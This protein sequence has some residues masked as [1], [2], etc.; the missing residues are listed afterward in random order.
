MSKSMRFSKWLLE[1][2]DY[3]FG[4]ESMKNSNDLYDDTEK[5]WSLFKTEE[6]FNELRSLI[7]SDNK[8]IT[9]DWQTYIDWI[10][11]NN[12]ISV[13]INPFGSLRI[14]TRKTIKDLNGDSVN[15]CKHVFDVNDHDVDQEKNIANHIY[16]RAVEAS[17]DDSDYA[18]GEYNGTKKLARELF[19]ATQSKHPKN[20]MFP[21]KFLEMNS[22]YY[23]IVFEFRGSGAGSPNQSTALQFNIDIIFDKEKG[24][25]RCWGYDIDS[26]SNKKQFNIKPSEWDEYFSPQESNSKIISIIT[27][28]FMTY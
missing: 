2:A 12:N 1:Y 23:K 9:K 25:I 5:P 4:K 27:T 20:I 24:L 22:D 6:F 18:S 7:L 19:N 11:N 10:Q 28:T 8:Q 26:P 3:G 15:V 13:I 16:D 14:T 17:K 21:V